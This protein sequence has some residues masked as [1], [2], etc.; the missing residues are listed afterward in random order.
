MEV[1]IHGKGL[2]PPGRMAAS[3]GNSAVDSGCL[4]LV[5]PVKFYLWAPGQTLRE[6]WDLGLLIFPLFV[7]PPYRREQASTISDWNGSTCGVCLLQ[8]PATHGAERIKGFSREGKGIHVSGTRN[9]PFPFQSSTEPCLT[10]ILDPVG[11][12][13]YRGRAT[14]TWNRFHMEDLRLNAM[15]FFSSTTVFQVE[16]CVSAIFI[17]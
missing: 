12:S 14:A 11:C 15:V 4:S 16:S 3:S 17:K 10:L 1:R 13:G 7:A 8:P 6:L 9:P 2:L 5:L